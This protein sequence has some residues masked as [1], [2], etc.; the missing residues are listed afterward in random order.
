MPVYF[1]AFAGTSVG[2]Q[3]FTWSGTRV[4]DESVCSPVHFIWSTTPPFLWG[5]Q[6]FCTEI[7]HCFH[8]PSGVLLVGRYLV[9]HSSSSATALITDTRTV[10]V[11]PQGVTVCLRDCHRTRLSDSSLLFVPFEVSVYYYY[12]Y[13]YWK[14]WERMERLMFRAG[15][16]LKTIVQQNR[17]ETKMTKQKCV[18][19]KTW[20]PCRLQTCAKSSD[21][22]R[23]GTCGPP[24]LWGQE[25]PQQWAGRCT[26][27]PV[28]CI[29]R[30]CG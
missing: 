4:S 7:A 3:V 17:I 11:F 13:Y 1:P 19:T 21:R 20:F 25:T 6:T 15:V 9:E 28:C 5:Q 23:P 27:V 24:S 30:P 22:G 14:S 12:Y 10:Q 2:V 29:S 8:E 26:G 18:E 16:Q